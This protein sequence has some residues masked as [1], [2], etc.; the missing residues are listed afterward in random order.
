VNSW[1][2]FWKVPQTIA[3]IS[4]PS[5][6]RKM[7]LYAYAEVRPNLGAKRVVELSQKLEDWR[8]GKTG[9]ICSPS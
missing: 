2:F 5:T 9:D 1:I 4:N 3:Q 7:A 6:T 8:D